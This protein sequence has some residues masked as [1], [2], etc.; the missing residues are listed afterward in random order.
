MESLSATFLLL[1]VLFSSIGM[2]FLVYGKKQRKAVPFVA[3]LVLIIYTFF[4]TNIWLL[5]GIGLVMIALP[6]II[7]E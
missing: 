3:G 7:K 4:V 6:F 5:I 1:G 2:G